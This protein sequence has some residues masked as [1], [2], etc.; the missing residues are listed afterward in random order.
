MSAARGRFITL[1]G[2]E[3]AGKS[4][5]RERVVEWLR[6]AGIDAVV[7][8]EPGGAPAAERIRALLLDPEQSL[9]AP[10][11]ELLLVFAARAEHVARRIGPALAQGRWVVCD[12][13]VDATYAYQGGGRG[14]DRARIAALERFTL[15]D[16]R[17]D[18]TLLFDLTP[19]KG[20]ARAGRR[21]RPDRFETEGED[22]FERARAAYLG[23][24]QQAP[25]RIRVIDAEQPLESVGA[26]VERV[27][28]AFVAA[29]GAGASP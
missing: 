23:L 9:L 5:Q 4:T 21:S 28:A 27:L 8:R 15:G 2:I 7:T 29:C 14:I 10:D 1:E 20:L 3:G 6:R 12:R 22:F 25:Q 17:P 18:L 26:E 19:A 13:F 11:T 24:A 16:L